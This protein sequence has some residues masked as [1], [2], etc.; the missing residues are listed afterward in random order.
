M[1]V[2]VSRFDV[3]S[4]SSDQ[5]VIVDQDILYYLGYGLRLSHVVAFRSTPFCCLRLHSGLILFGNNLSNAE[6]F[7]AEIIVSR[8]NLQ[9][10]LATRS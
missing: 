9:I 1:H 7:Q 3:D 10:F 4:V 8:L 5:E 2:E 6:Q